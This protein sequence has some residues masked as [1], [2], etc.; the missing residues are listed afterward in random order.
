MEFGLF[1]Q[2]YVPKGRRQ[3]DPEAEHHVI[4][5]DL[6]AVIAADKAGFKF[7]WI[8]EHHFLDEYSHLSANDVVAGYLAAKTE[9]IHIGGGIFNPLPAV[10]HPAKLA[11]RITYLDHVSN[12]RVEFGTGRGAGSH[13]ILGFLQHLGITDTT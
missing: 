12:G 5:E 11:E 13:E 6:E 4:F 9:R 8:T 7:V 2:N 3:N 10:N 1:I